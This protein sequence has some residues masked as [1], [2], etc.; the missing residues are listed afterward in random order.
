MHYL[1]GC[2]WLW[3]APEAQEHLTVSRMK[4]TDMY[5]YG[6][7]AWRVLSNCSNPFEPILR[8]SGYKTDYRKGLPQLKESLE[9]PL[10]VME[11]IPEFRKSEFADELIATTL[12]YDPSHRSLDSAIC[13]L[14]GNP[15][16]N[17]ESRHHSEYD[18]IQH[19]DDPANA[20]TTLASSFP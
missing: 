18:N 3:S 5:S 4:L 9:F 20:M 16:N 1:P 2:T 6:L 17:C 13:A 11:T 10:L 7:I 19:L 15:N 12:S 8:D 14:A